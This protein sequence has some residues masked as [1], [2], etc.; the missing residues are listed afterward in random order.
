MPPAAGLRAHVDLSRISGHIVDNACRLTP[1]TATAESQ[2]QHLERTT[3]MLD[4][5][6]V[7]LPPTLQLVD[8]L[9]SD[10]ACGMLHM[11]SNQ[12]LILASRPLFFAAVKRSFA[13]RVV[14][15]QSS[16]ESHPQ[17]LYLKACVGAAKHNIRLA[18]HLVT[19]NRRGKLLYS[20]L[21][22]LLDAAIVVLLHELANDETTP[23]EDNS[24]ND[25]AADVDFVM[26]RLGEEARLG[27]SY[28]RDAGDTLR[29][30]KGVLT[31]LKMPLDPG[32][33]AAESAMG[34][35]GPYDELTGW[36]DSDWLLHGCLEG[37][38]E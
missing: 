32:M 9:T 34:E 1:D 3:W 13:E 36:M 25:S 18:R 12:L 37:A 15:Q 24:F 22:I 8:G 27:S 10:P 26:Q 17:A 20:S 14:T 21:H 28:A 7:S 35:G 19:L 31:R 11:Q 2:S 30:L 6:Q 5:W 4:Q 33:V 23:T 38:S 16:F 29:S